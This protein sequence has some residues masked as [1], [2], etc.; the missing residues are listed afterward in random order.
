[1]GVNSLGSALEGPW[2]YAP[3]VGTTNNHVWK[4]KRK[5]DGARGPIGVGPNLVGTNVKDLG[6]LASNIPKAFNH[7]PDSSRTTAPP[8]PLTSLSVKGK[9]EIAR[10]MAHQINRESSR[11]WV[12][13]SF[14]PSNPQPHNEPSSEN[15]QNFQFLATSGNKVDSDKG[16]CDME[17]PSGERPTMGE[18]ATPMVGVLGGC[19][20]VEEEVAKR[21]ESSPSKTSHADS[22]CGEPP[23][24]AIGKEDA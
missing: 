11:S 1:M 24:G 22:V 19:T 3:C 8:S 7:G 9:K 18:N 14:Y 16:E 20:F 12:L 15:Q 17:L 23:R 5:A 6:H 2:R 10:G 4:G 13:S 21:M